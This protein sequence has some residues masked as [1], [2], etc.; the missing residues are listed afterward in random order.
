MK[1]LLGLLLVLTMGYPVSADVLKNV[2]LKGEVQ[3]IGSDVRDHRLEY[4]TGTS[5]RVLAGA[6]FDLVEDVRANLLF[7]F[8]YRRRKRFQRSTLLG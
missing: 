3:V 6:S 1:K 5:L 2:D 7:G 8:F 4:N